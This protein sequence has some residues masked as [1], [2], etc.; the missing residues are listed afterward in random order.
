MSLR[1]AFVPASLALALVACS[2]PSDAP[3]PVTFVKGQILERPVEI[4]S[5]RRK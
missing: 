3:T 5:I 2:Q 1:S 4:L